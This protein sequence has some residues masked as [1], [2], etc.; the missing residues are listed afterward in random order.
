MHQLQVNLPPRSTT[1]SIT[2]ERGLLERLGSLVRT[3][4]R[5]ERVLL[6]VD[7][8]I[9]NT[10]AEV[11]QRSLARAGLEVTTHP[12]VA[13]ESGKT[14]DTVQAMYGSMLRA[15]LERG[16]VVIALG[17]GIVGDIAGFAAATWLRGVPVVQVP[18][19]LLAMVDASIGGKTGVNLHL[20]QD[21]LA[22]NMVGAFW[23]PRAVLVDPET[24]RTLNARDF[25][26]GLAE[27]V[28]HGLI[29][30]AGLI[31]FVD[32]NRGLIEQLDMDALTALIAQSAAV[33]VAIVQEDE[34]EAGRRALLNL[35]HTF[36]H[37]L[38]GMRE[39]DLRHGEAV[40]IGL[41]A[42]MRC[43]VSTGRMSESDAARI[44]ALLARL[45]LP[46]ELSGSATT[47]ARVR[48]AMGHDK[49]VEQGRQRLV[50]PVGIGDATVADDIS[51]EVI[52]EALLAI[53][54]AA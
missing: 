5:H 36:G 37:A 4:V 10:H 25:R 27:C 26:C 41:V 54:A 47:A 40:S 8:G 43:S 11:A 2:I 31:D 19:T 51:G 42:A 32:D 38:E 1:Y 7:A 33:K 13:A 23:Q 50:L 16:S 20:S 45:G 49:K 14:L 35:G 46:I 44:R 48:A 9:L 12:I 52:D 39:L 53:G 15:K 24:L 21:E 30:D 28:K 17:G 6:A 18:T 29:A 22:K 34:R 3:L